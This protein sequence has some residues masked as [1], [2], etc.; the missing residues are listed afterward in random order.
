MDEIKKLCDL[1][2]AVVVFYRT[3]ESLPPKLVESLESTLAKRGY[4]IHELT[5][6]GTAVLTQDNEWIVK[7]AYEFCDRLKT[8]AT[9]S[10]GALCQ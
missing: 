1:L 7:A 5:P 4:Q 8:G 9:I 2:L 10:E 6:N 3:G